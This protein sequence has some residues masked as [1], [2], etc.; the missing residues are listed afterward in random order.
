M[1]D[2][3]WIFLALYDP[4]PTVRNVFRLLGLGYELFERFSLTFSMSP[5]LDPPF[6]SA[7]PILPSKLTNDI[8]T[9]P[10]QSCFSV[11][12][13]TPYLPTL[14]GTFL[15]IRYK[16]TEHSQFSLHLLVH[17]WYTINLSASPPDFSE[18]CTNGLHLLSFLFSTGYTLLSKVMLMIFLWT[19]FSLPL[20]TPL[21]SIWKPVRVLGSHY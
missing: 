10:L 13:P 17:I 11:L 3:H 8:Q 15:M 1:R 20:P 7:T 4:I 18:Y 12:N 16:G 9:T 14:T 6:L 19:L 5:C 2:G 21:C